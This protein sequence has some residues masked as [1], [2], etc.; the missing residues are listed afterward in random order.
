[1]NTN[2]SCFSKIQENETAIQILTRSSY[3]AHFSYLYNF[4]LLICFPFYIHV[5]RMNMAHNKTALI[6]PF[7]NYFHVS[8]KFTYIVFYCEVCF[9]QLVEWQVYDAY[10]ILATVYTVAVFSIAPIL[11]WTAPINHILLSILAMYRSIL[12]FF[13]SAE[14]F[15][16]FEDKNNRKLIYF[17]WLLYVFVAIITFSR[18]STSYIP[19][20]Y[21]ETNKCLEDVIYFCRYADTSTTPLLIQLSFLGCNRRHLQ[22]LILS[23]RPRIGLKVFCCPCADVAQTGGIVVSRTQVSSTSIPLS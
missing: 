22:F 14:P 3:S 21:F 19:V 13:P 8:V 20:A 6:Y 16:K 12:F 23:L 9:H 18:F 15:M 5:Y 17:I 1:M 11:D 2:F 7:F 10:G 4:L